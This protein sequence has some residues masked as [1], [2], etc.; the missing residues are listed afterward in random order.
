MSSLILF[1]FIDEFLEV[2][3]F[4]DFFS[5]SFDVQLGFGLF[6]SDLFCCVF[7][8]RMVFDFQGSVYMNLIL[9]VVGIFNNVR[10]LLLSVNSLFMDIMVRVCV[11]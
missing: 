9:S 6:F 7:F 3:I 10:R 2:S 8:F 1:V 11:L 4:F 5:L